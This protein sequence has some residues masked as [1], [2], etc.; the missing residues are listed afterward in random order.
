MRASEIQVQQNASPE[1]GYKQPP[2]Q[3]KGIPRQIA[4]ETGLSVDTVR[5]A[6]NPVTNIKHVQAAES[7]AEAVIREANAIVSAW[8]RARQAARELALEQ[9]DAP[10][11]DNTR[12]AHCA[13]RILIA[14]GCDAGLALAEREV[15]GLAFA[16]IIPHPDVHDLHQNPCDIRRRKRLHQGEKPVRRSAVLWLDH[17]FHYAGHS[18]TEGRP[19]HIPLLSGH[20]FA[21][22][23]HDPH[24]VRKGPGPGLDARGP[25]SFI[26]GTCRLEERRV[27]G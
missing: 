16:G 22:R 6:L 11:F 12:T 14:S 24:K 20:G 18:R 8:N 25:E 1:I 10:V 13:P 17:V 27:C 15:L 5:R 4:D 21:V 2:P 19:C 23:Q 9:I 3:T 7:E 26:N